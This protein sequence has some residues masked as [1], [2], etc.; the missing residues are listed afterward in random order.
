MAK[1]YRWRSDTGAAVMVVSAEKCK[2][3]TQPTGKKLKSA[4]GQLIELVDEATV[5]VRISGSLA[6]LS[7]FGYLL[8]R[9]ST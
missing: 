4:T 9:L 7:L 6:L 8:P 2:I 1:P 3:P 5:E